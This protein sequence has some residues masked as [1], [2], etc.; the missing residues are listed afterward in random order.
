VLLPL[1]IVRCLSADPS[2]AAA[3]GRLPAIQQLR[4]QATHWALYALLHC[5][6]VVGW[7]A[8]SAYRAPI[9]VFWLFESAADLAGERA[10]S[11]RM[12]ALTAGSAS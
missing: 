7:I 9:A 2:G 1:A 6:A 12:F 8:T 4:P 10:V 3:A 5:A 11:E